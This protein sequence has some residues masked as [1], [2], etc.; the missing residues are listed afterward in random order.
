MQKRVKYTIVTSL[1]DSLGP[2]ESTLECLTHS[3]LTIEYTTTHHRAAEDPLDTKDMSN[4]A[5]VPTYDGDAR[6]T[7][8]R[9]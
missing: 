1:T 4:R 8:N 2:G 6:P 7:Q 5:G 3:V 9:D